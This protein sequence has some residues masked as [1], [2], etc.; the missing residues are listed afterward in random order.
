MKGLYKF[1]LLIG[2]PFVL[3]IGVM[4]WYNGTAK[5]RGAKMRQ[6]ILSDTAAVNRAYRTYDRIHHEQLME[7][8]DYRELYEEAEDLK[9]RLQRI[10]QYAD[11][12]EGSLDYFEDKGFDVSELQGIFDDIESECY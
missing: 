11:D 2:W 10:S 3:V 4:V 1:V 7:D 12:A 9:D 5:D 6:E 8:P